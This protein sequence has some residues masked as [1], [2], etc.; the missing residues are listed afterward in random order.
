MKEIKAEQ[1]K[2]ESTIRSECY[3][4]EW[5]KQHL[6]NTPI[7]KLTFADIRGSTTLLAQKGNG[8]QRLSRRS[9][10]YYF[11]VMRNIL[12]RPVENGCMNLVTVPCGFHVECGQ[13]QR[14]L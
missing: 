2:C 3:R 6:G 7:N 13:R 1:V 14:L 11:T 12:N 9:L 10:N 5:W 8:D 4:V